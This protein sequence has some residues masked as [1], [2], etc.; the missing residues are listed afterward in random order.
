MLIPILPIDGCIVAE[1]CG[2]DGED[3]IVGG[4]GAARSIIRLETNTKL[5]AQFSQ[6]IF[7]HG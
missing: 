7:L 6:R 2:Q 3:V 1:E 4:R 5:V